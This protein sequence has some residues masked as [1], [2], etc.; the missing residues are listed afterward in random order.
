MKVSLVLTRFYVSD[1]D[2]AIEFYEKL[3]NEN[4]KLRF[5]KEVPN[6]GLL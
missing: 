6:G 2:S 4:C 3:L 5:K 1:L